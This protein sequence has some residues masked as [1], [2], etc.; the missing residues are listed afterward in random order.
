MRP[1]IWLALATSSA[2]ALDAPQKYV[3][4][5]QYQYPPP[6]YEQPANLWDEPAPQDRA[7]LRPFRL[8]TQQS[9]AIVYA[10]MAW[11]FTTLGARARAFSTPLVG[12]LEKPY[13]VANVACAGL[14]ARAATKHKRLLKAVLGCNVGLEALVFATSVLTSLFPGPGGGAPP[15]GHAVNALCAFWMCLINVTCARSK[16]IASLPARAPASATAPYG[17]IHQPSGYPPPPPI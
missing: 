17:S 8:A 2:L 15:E 12:G 11:R 13:F 5:A 7:V 14:A 3:A 10:L 9:V 4:R 16:W 1:A 6:Q